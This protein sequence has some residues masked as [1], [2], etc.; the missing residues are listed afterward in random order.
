MEI[1]EFTVNEAGVRLDKF[2]SD[3]SSLSRS[4]ATALIEEGAVTVNGKKHFVNLSKNADNN[5]IMEV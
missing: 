1:L 3:N 2:L 4:A 5:F